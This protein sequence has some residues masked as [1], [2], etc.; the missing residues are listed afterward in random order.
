VEFIDTCLFGRMVVLDD[1]IQ[2]TEK[3][4][5]IYH[6]ALVHPAMITH[7]EPRSVLIIGGGEGA[8]LREVLRHDTVSRVTMVDIDEEFVSLCRK[9]LKKWHKG[10]FHDKRVEL[11]FGDAS[12]Y[13]KERRAQFDVI[14]TDVSDPVDKGPA[15]PIYMKKFYLMAKKA[16]LPDGLFVTHANA[17]SCI[18][19]KNIASRIFRT[20]GGVFP[21][22][23]LYYEYIPSYGTLWSFVIGSL[24]YSPEAVSVDAAEKRIRRRN[25]RDLL[26]YD[27]EV[28]RRLFRLSKCVSALLAPGSK[29]FVV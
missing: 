20:V 23:N 27:P 11:V 5:F 4:E 18:S 24:K 6:E 1:K 9:H 21:Q 15:M 10:S 8:T 28:H 17:I 16:L 12:E 19:G 29:R 22:A 7:P 14:I 26:Y 25:L 3:D 13:L 2:S